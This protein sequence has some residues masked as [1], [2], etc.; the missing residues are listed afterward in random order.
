MQLGWF[1][2]MQTQADR[3]LL[4]QRGLVVAGRHVTLHSRQVAPRQRDVA[5][6]TLKDL[7]LY[8]ISNEDILEALKEIC[9]VQSEVQYSNVWYDGKPTIRNG[10]WFVYIALSNMAKLPQHLE[11]AGAMSQIFKPISH[12]KCKWCGNEGHRAGDLKCPA[13]APES[14]TD[15]VEVFQ[16]GGNPLLNLHICPEGCEIKDQGTSFPSSEHHYQFKKLKHHDMGE[17]VY[18]LLIEADSFKAMKKAKELI[19]DEKTSDKWKVMACDKM[20]TTN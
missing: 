9:P 1:I 3:D 8:S 15:D 5:K 14:M 16:G 10:D 12:M 11:I 7:P 4:I 17:Q 20:H 13:R 19:L 6:V 18:L 2:Y